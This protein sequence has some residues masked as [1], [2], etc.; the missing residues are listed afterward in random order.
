VNRFERR[1]LAWM[2]SG[3]GRQWIEW[4]PDEI[5]PRHPH[6]FRAG[7]TRCG[8]QALF[9]KEIADLLAPSP[10]SQCERWIKP[11]AN[12]EATSSARFG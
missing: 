8:M 10:P 3:G 1:A 4:G 11:L 5:T 6:L 9:D 12:C 2:Q 7:G